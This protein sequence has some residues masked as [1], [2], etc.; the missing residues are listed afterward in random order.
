MK[1]TGA[2]AQNAQR[3]GEFDLG[4]VE[5]VVFDL[6][7]TLI[8]SAPDLAVALN[9]VLEMKGLEPLETAQVRF[10]IGAGVAKLIER[11]F[12]ARNVE[13]K[14][15]EL[16][17]ELLDAFLSYYNAHADDLTKVYPGGVVA[18]KNAT[19]DIKD[20]EFLVLVGPSGSAMSSTKAC[21]TPIS[22]PPGR[23]KSKLPASG[24][25]PGR[26][27]RLFTTPKANAS[28]PEYLNFSQANYIR[29]EWIF[30]FPD[31]DSR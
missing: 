1:M 21:S 13:M 3:L 12:R 29:P 31:S 18:V 6:D 28:G 14:A 11:G 15:D 26:R 23:L 19:L 25:P 2:L 9:L 20:K 10:M 27:C 17:P 22:L 5:G 8:D 7:G 4:W 30:L 24:A 16:D